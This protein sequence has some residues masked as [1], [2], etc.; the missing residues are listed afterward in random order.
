MCIC[1]SCCLRNII[2]TFFLLF[3]SFCWIPFWPHENKVKTKIKDILYIVHWLIAKPHLNLILNLTL[4]SHQKHINSSLGLH[5][6]PH[7][8][9]LYSNVS[10]LLCDSIHCSHALD[11]C[12]ADKRG[13]RR[14]PFQLIHILWG[15]QPLSATRHLFSLLSSKEPQSTR[16]QSIGAFTP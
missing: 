2:T 10:L 13:E 11:I 1:G 15:C 4:R 12:T 9:Q 3:L 8:K 16:D 7:L 5:V 6:K 14:S